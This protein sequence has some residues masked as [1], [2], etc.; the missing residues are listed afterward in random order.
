MSFKNLLFV[1]LVLFIP[2]TASAQSPTDFE[3]FQLGPDSALVNSGT[4]KFFHSDIFNLPND[5]NEA[6]GAWSGW[7]ISSKT[8]SVSAGFTNEL[9]S[10]AGQGKDSRTYAVAYVAGGQNYIA[11]DPTTVATVKGIYISN[12][13]YGYRS[14]EQ[15]DAFAK[16]FGGLTGLDP[17][18]FKLTIGAIRN[19]EILDEK[20]EVYLA[21][22]RSTNPSE[23]FILKGWKEVPLNFSEIDSITFELSSSDVGAFG[24]NTP[25]YFCIDNIAFDVTTNTKELV[26]ANNLQVYPNP[27]SQF[28]RLDN[29]A[30]SLKTWSIY[31]VNGQLVERQTNTNNEVA[32]SN[33]SAGLYTIVVKTSKGLFTDRFMKI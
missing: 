16:K 31:D 11:I 27:S 20:V 5:Y 24:M 1:S 23:D 10:I 14:M 22:F 33:L 9:S 15:G 30:E 28:I 19:G 32:V 12:S 6:W 29:V 8:D 13:T 3:K 4:Q 21:D 2:I 17:D 25:A 18:F 7:A 26:V